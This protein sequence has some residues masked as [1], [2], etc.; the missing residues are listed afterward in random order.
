MLLSPA[1]AGQPQTT[2][3][4]GSCRGSTSCGQ[5]AG[6]DSGFASSASLLIWPGH[7][8]QRAGAA[9]PPV[10]VQNVRIGFGGANAFK[11]GCWTPV[12]VQLK[13]GP[14]RFSGFM[15]LMVPDDDGTPTSYRQPMDSGADESCGYTAYV[16][17]GGQDTEFTVGILRRQG[18]R[19]LELPQEQFMPSAPEVSCPTRC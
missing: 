11:I 12:R 19:M 14:E 7:G 5:R 10:E 4:D 3:V 18:R 15:E 1:G 8:R 2:A 9:P 13:A 6:A 16:R 17:P